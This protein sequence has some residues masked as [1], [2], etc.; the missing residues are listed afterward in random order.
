MLRL[1]SILLILVGLGVLFF[2]HA[3]KYFHAQEERQLV[4]EFLELEQVFTSVDA[5]E[6]EER[7]FTDEAAFMEE[8]ETV[9]TSDSGDE[10]DSNIDSTDNQ[11]DPF[12]EEGARGNTIAIIE[13]DRIGLTLPI[14][15]GASEENLKVGAGH[16]TGTTPIGETGNAGIA[17][18]RSHT[19]GRQFNRLDEIK[20][21]D[22]VRITTRNGEE[23]YQVFELDV[24]VPEDTSVLEPMG[25]EAVITLI[26]CEPMINPTHRLIVHAKR[27][28]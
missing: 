1:I 22:L 7:A 21:G 6:T 25:D 3:Q 20:E 28:S 8:L 16:L 9:Q 27:I 12:V 23:E 4:E 17:A 10:V 26:T 18:H 19:Y 5:D 11:S 13:I 2:P 24:V 15:Q 14:L